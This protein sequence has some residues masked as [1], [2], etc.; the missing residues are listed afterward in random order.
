[1][2]ADTIALAHEVISNGPDWEGS[3]SVT[4]ARALIAQAEDGRRLALRCTML[5]L[6]LRKAKYDLEEWR[7]IRNG[8]SRDAL[9]NGP[10]ID[11][12]IADF[13]AAIGFG[14][15]GFTI[16]ID[17]ETWEFVRTPEKR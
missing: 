8:Q 9:S 10:A 13:N 2:T 4:L 17:P 3:E 5:G 1:V 7:D 15:P 16:D 6:L 14:S 11:A 12:D